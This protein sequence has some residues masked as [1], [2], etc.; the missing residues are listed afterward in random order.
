[1]IAGADLRVGQADLR[2]H[3]GQQDVVRV[4]D[5]NLGQQRPRGGIQGVGGAHDPA[6]ELAA[7]PLLHA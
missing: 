7:G 4:L 1:M 6:G 5:V 3:S 2:V